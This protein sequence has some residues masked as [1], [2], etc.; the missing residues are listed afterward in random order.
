MIVPEDV[1]T[2]A[3]LGRFG[4]QYVWGELRRAGFDVRATCKGDGGDLLACGLRIEVK[5][6]AQN[7]DGGFRFCLHKDDKKGKTDHRKSDVIIL[8]C[9]SQAGLITTFV[10][11]IVAIVK[12]DN[13]RLPRTRGYRGKYAEYRKPLIKGLRR[14]M[15]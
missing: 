9:C 8:I 13:L 4:E 14:W 10:I 6:A 3:K 1:N 5:T 7:K 2:P 15:L 11:P 12:K